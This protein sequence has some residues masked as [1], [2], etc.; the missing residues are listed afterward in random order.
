M[1]ILTASRPSTLLLTLARMGAGIGRV[2]NE[3]VHASLLTDYYEPKDHPKVFAL[4]RLANPIGLGS[5]LVVGVLGSLFDWRFV[6][7]AL[8][9]PTFLLLPALLRLREPVRAES[10]DGLHG[11]KAA[12]AGRI[13]FGEARGSCSRSARCAAFDRLPVLGWRCCDPRAADEPV[14]RAGLRLRP[15]RRG[16]VT[17]PVRASA[18]C[19]ASGTGQRLATQR[20]W[21]SSPSGWRPTT[22]A[23]SWHRESAWSAWCSPRPRLAVRAVQ[24]G[25]GSDRGLPALLL[26]ARR[27]RQPARIRAQAYA[28]AILYLGGGALF[29][30][31]LADSA[32]R[33]ATARARQCSRRRSSPRPA[34]VVTTASKSVRRD[35][36]QALASLATA[37]ELDEQLRSTGERALLT[38]RGPTSPTTAC[39]CCSAWTSRSAR[40][41]SSRCSARTARAS[42]R[43]STP[44]SGLTD[45]VGGSIFYDGRDITHADAVQTA[46]SASSRCPAARALSPR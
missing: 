31:T 29:A 17:V 8:C 34:T 3:P 30:P 33:R 46:T 10:V 13:P 42:R 11:D 12:A 18:S 22:A 21:T 25:G 39:R 20:S 19:S 45:P 6:F 35:A 36:E 23:P 4:H 7:L 43:C 37:A 14:L 40:G 32:S 2:V 44:V 16:V 28:W 1:T 38:V 26:H 9:V 5:A 24:P 15:H 27:R 41:R